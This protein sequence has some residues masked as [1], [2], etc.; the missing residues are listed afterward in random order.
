MSF[1]SP[2]QTNL[3]GTPRQTGNMQSLGKDDFLQL[4][5][6]KLEHQ[7]PMDPMDDADFVAQLAQFSTLEQMNN[8]AQGITTSNELDL[9]QSQS[10]N[11]TMAAGLIG[12]DVRAK[13]NGVYL[14]VNEEPRITYTIPEPAEEVVIRIK[15]IDGSTVATISSNGLS[16]GTHSTIWDGLDDRGNRAPDGYYTLEIEATGPGGN[17]IT[18]SMALEGPVDSIVYRQGTAFLRV[19]GTEIP[20]GD[21]TAIG[22]PGAFT[23]DDEDN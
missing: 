22:A 18:P 12:N 9:L 11:N 1:I 20:L 5:I 19:N 6:A 15:D 4:L 17:G 8:I 10:I 7:D 16:A 14:S 2:I 3:D 21:I 23:D 13:Y